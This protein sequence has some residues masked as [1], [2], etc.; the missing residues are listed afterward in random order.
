ML[1]KPN[2]T[3]NFS[4]KC[5]KSF[6]L[7]KSVSNPRCPSCVQLEANNR[8]K[9]K[10]YH[11]LPTYKEKRFENRLKSY[12]ITIELY[13][14]MLEQ[15]GGV[16]AICKKNDSRHRL[17]V[18]HDHNTGKVRGLLCH[19]C[20]RTLGV[21][22]DNIDLFRSCS[23]YLMKYEPLKNWDDYFLDIASLVATR[24]KDPST[25]VGAVIVRDKVILSTGY[26]GF[27]T[28]VDDT[29]L[30]RYTRPEKYSWTIH[31]EENAIFNASRM[32]IKLDNS[33]IY[34][35]PMSPCANCALSICQ[36][37]IK[38]VIYKKTIENPRFEQSF[39]QAF[40]IFNASKILVRQPEQ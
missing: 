5:G 14:E 10:Q 18:D 40:E 39:Q 6:T 15:Q 31:A 34:V 22:N 24:S 16:C 30:H 35:V 12:G 17:S 1:R 32:G 29:I 28:G 3:T 19:K 13:N 37:G 7:K 8:A 33:K 26:N 20:N 38:E 36:S 21:F 9:S 4:C 2:K 27:P 23:S 11:T 25:K